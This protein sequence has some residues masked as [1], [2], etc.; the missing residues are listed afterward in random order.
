[1]FDQPTN[2]F[3][4]KIIYT[5]HDSNIIES[6]EYLVY[7]NILVEYFRAAGFILVDGKDEFFSNIEMLKQEF[8]VQSPG[9]KTV[10]SY[11]RYYIFQKTKEVITE[12]VAAAVKSAGG[13]M[14][15]PFPVEI[16]D[17]D[18]TYEIE[19]NEIEKVPPPAKP[20]KPAKKKSKKRMDDLLGGN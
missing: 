6:E 9:E 13:G 20:V 5:L 17:V 12:V 16:Y 18:V 15:P 4:N 7:N 14:E 8:E 1:M 2:R 19:E 11:Q 10:S 3:G